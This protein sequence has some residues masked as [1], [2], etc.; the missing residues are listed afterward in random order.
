MISESRIL[1]L[2]NP[3]K[4]WWH[5]RSQNTSSLTMC[6]GRNAYSSFLPCTAK[7]SF[8]MSRYTPAISAMKICTTKLE[9]DTDRYSTLVTSR[10]E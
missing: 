1:P 7:R 2:M 10:L 8:S 9:I 3:A 6:S 4:M 5:L